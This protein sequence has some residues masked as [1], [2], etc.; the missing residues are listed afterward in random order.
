MEIYFIFSGLGTYCP[1]NDTNYHI[2]SVEIGE[3]VECNDGQNVCQ[4]GVCLI[5][6]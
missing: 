1:T 3:F 5:N 6:F 2:G 4:N